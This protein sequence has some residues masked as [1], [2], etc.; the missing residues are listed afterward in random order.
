MG[1]AALGLVSGFFASASF[2]ADGLGAGFAATTGLAAAGFLEAAGFA[3]DVCFAADGFAVLGLA[4][5]SFAA[6][7]LSVWA[8]VA[9]GAVSRS[10]AQLA[11]VR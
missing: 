2:G 1:A 10:T 7:G 8:K 3:T 11:V 5:L 9:T 4:E 6:A